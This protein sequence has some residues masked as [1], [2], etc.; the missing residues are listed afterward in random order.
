MGITQSRQIIT[1]FLLPALLAVALLALFL[2]N[3]LEGWAIERWSNNQ[4]E[5][6]NLLQYTAA[7]PEFTQSLDQSKIDRSLNGIPPGVDET[8]RHILN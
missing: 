7:L 5:F 4:Y 2:R 3:E 8:K 6:A 1:L